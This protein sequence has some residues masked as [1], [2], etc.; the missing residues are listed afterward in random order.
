MPRVGVETL[1]GNSKI[2]E[3]SHSFLTE[4]HIS[5]LN[6]SMY[7]LVGMQIDKSSQHRLQYACNFVLVETALSDVQQIDDGSCL[8]IL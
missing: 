2:S 8:T 3:L 4:Q 1:S 7:L 5:S 6:I